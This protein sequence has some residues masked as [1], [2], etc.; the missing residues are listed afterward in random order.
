M[1][2]HYGDI[3]KL[4]GNPWWYI[5]LRSDRTV[6][7]TLRR[8]GKAIPPIFR[9]EAVEFFIPV[10]KRD[11]DVF[12]LETSVYVFV[13]ST[14]FPCLLR[15][16]SV[17][18]VVSLVTEGETN[19]PHK[20]IRVEDDYVQ[21][22]IKTVERHFY[23]RAEGI[24]PGSFVRIIDGE[25]RDYAGHVLLV[26]DGKA[27]V[28]VDLK[29]K[30]LLVETPVRN[31]LNLSHVPEAQRVF[32]YSPLVEHLA[33]DIALVAEDLKFADNVA[34]DKS[35]PEIQ[36]TESA[37][38]KRFTRQRTVTALVKRLVGEGIINP[39]RIATEVVVAIRKKDIKP[40]KN[41]LIAYCILKDTLMKSHFLKLNPKLR[42]YRDVIHQYGESYRFS[43]A[44]IAAIDPNVGI[45]VTTLEP[46]KDG[47]S[48]AAREQKR[49]LVE[50][51]RKRV[52]AMTAKTALK[53]LLRKRMIKK[54]RTKRGA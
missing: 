17:T 35:L 9:Q 31:L 51:E 48:R 42:N 1:I 19:R 5:E 54:G 45:P 3:S 36:M 50:S 33:D 52:G 12:D 8:V 25:T 37:A 28:R 44:D 26:A 16:K 20:A 47:R 49:I 13:R 10:S 24:R 41:L 43:P 11:L 2:L 7:N 6:E 46:A 40:P 34:F 22:L 23:E 27:C 29:T 32:Y 21:D 30:S 39:M 14:S 4:R 38:P 15:L 18:G 53:S